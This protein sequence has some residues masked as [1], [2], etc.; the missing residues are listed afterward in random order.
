[1]EEYLTEYIK[2]FQYGLK[3]YNDSNTRFIIINFSLTPRIIVKFIKNNPYIK[4]AY[5]GPYYNVPND[6]QDLKFENLTSN[7]IKQRVSNNYATLMIELN[8][9]ETEIN[10]IE[11]KTKAIDIGSENEF[12][13][14]M[15]E[16]EITVYY[17]G[18]EKEILIISIALEPNQINKD[19]KFNI[20]IEG[21]NNYLKTQNIQIQNL[22]KT[23][24]FDISEG[25]DYKII[26][27][28][29]NDIKGKFKIFYSDDRIYIKN[30]DIIIYNE[31]FLKFEPSPLYMETYSP[32]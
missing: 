15:S 3:K 10:F 7:L 18:R 1:M 8:K 5:H 27:E 2:D 28:N 30:N 14:T 19:N 17:H 32:D 25:G 22:N 23:I 12:N 4:I 20:K 6:V 21:P 16:F 13:L 9:E 29:I 31:I 26:Y 11:D 24:F